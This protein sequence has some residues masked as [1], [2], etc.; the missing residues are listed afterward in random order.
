MRDVIATKRDRRRSALIPR[1][2]GQTDLYSCPARWPS[3]PPASRASAG[4]VGRGV[5]EPAELHAL[6]R[7]PDPAAA[8]R[9]VRARDRRDRLDLPHGVLRRLLRHAAELARP[10]RASRSGDSWKN[11]RHRPVDVDR[12]AV[13]HRSAARVAVQRRRRRC[14]S[15]TSCPTQVGRLNAL[16]PRPLGDA[17]IQRLYALDR[18]APVPDA[19]GAL[20]GGQQR[21][22]LQRRRAVRA[23][24]PRTPARSATTC[25]T[26][27]CACS[28]SR[29]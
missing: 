6:R 12:A 25:A 19:Q 17:D 14:R 16:H 5:L 4:V 3:I 27:C 11:A 8:R 24:R 26:T 13:L 29:S 7:A 21:A 23:R 2:S 18:R 22:D 20:H 28:G 15:K 1:R 9:A 10:P